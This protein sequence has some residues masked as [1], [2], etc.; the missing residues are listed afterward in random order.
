MSCTRYSLA[1][2]LKF[3]FQFKVSTCLDRTRE[4]PLTNALLNRYKPILGLVWK[5]NMQDRGAKGIRMLYDN[6]HGTWLS[7][8]EFCPIQIL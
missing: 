6:F 5:Q 1:E 3:D 4:D 7:S 8:A 2:D